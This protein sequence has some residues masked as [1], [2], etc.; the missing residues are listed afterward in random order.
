MTQNNLRYK[1]IFYDTDVRRVALVTLQL[2]DE[3]KTN[4]MRSNV[5]DSEFAKYRANKALVVSIEDVLDE[6]EVKEGYS[7]Y[8]PTFLYRVGE[9]VESEF[10][11]NTNKVCSSGIHYFKTKDQAKWYF[12]KPRDDGGYKEYYDNGQLKIH[13]IYFSG[14]LNGEYIYYDDRG[15]HIDEGVYC[16]GKFIRKE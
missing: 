16:D 2:L 7:Q 12:L 13:A 5:V 10:D 11:D 15:I 6:N 9:I 14:K 1:S 3:S 4:E 8:N